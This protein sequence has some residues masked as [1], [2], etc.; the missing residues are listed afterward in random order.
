MKI[1]FLDVD[2]VLNSIRSR[3]IFGSDYIDESCLTI[4]SS[5]VNKTNALLV[6]SSSWRLNIEDRRKISIALSKQNL[7]IWDF[8]PV[9]KIDEN[10]CVDRSEEIILWLSKN[11]VDKFAIIDDDPR[12]SIDGSFFKT[13]EYFGL[14]NETADRVVLH[15]NNL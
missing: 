7:K 8:T 13:N 1:I 3:K 12:A 10:S 2:G 15:L 11:S 4:L 9:I 5:I 6:L 14:T